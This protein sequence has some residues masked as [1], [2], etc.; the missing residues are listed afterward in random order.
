MAKTSGKLGLVILKKAMNHPGFE[1]SESTQNARQT[2]TQKLRYKCCSIVHLA[3][4]VADY[5]LHFGH[6]R[7][8]R[9]SYAS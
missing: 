5:L 7:I 2:R 1:R 6:A 8:Q 3:W 9:V 4:Q